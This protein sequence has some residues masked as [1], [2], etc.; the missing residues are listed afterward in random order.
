M[1]GSGGS[2]CCH[3]CPLLGPIHLLF[4]PP[5]PNFT[6]PCLPLP[7][8]AP[9]L[10]GGELTSRNSSCY[11]CRHRG[12]AQS[13]V[14]LPAGASPLLVTA[15]YLMAYLPLPRQR[16][17][18]WYCPSGGLGCPSFPLILFYCGR[19][20]QFSKLLSFFFWL[21]LKAAIFL[22]ENSPVFSL[23]PACLANKP[24]KINYVW[25]ENQAIIFSFRNNMKAGLQRL[26]SFLLPQQASY[27][28]C[29]LYFK[30]MGF[31]CNVNKM[32]IIFVSLS[33]DLTCSFL[34]LPNKDYG[35]QPSS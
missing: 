31:L 18:E 35:L 28:K 23:A 11:C 13:G 1:L 3:P 19:G 8:N 32:L 17:S 16:T 27:F 4:Q 34:F 24:S 12:P 22:I 33:L 14:G 2:L 26:S 7:R 25:Q 5:P 29:R 9:L 30:Y 21:F 6:P 20:F 15:M 10:L